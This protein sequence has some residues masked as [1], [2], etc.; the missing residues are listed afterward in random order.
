[1]ACGNCTNARPSAA[2]IRPALH[3]PE[4]HR[5]QRAGPRECEMREQARPFVDVLPAE[6]QEVLL[7]HALNELRGELLPDGSAVLVEYDAPRLV[8]HLPSALPGHVSQVGVFQVERLQHTVEAAQLEELVPV[9][10]ARSAAAVET[11]IQ[12]LYRRVVAVPDAQA[13]VLPPPLRQ[14]GLLAQF[15]RVAEKDLAGHRENI[16]V[17]KAFDQGREKPLVHPHIAVQQDDDIVPRLAKP[18]IRSTAEAQ[19]LRKRQHPHGRECGSHKLRAAV[20]RA[21]VHDD[22]FVVR[23]SGHGGDHR[24]QILFEKVFA[25]PVGNHDRSGRTRSL[26]AAALRVVREQLAAQVRQR[27]RDDRDRQQ[28]RRNQQQRKRLE[29]AFQQRH[30]KQADRGPPRSCGPVLSSASRVPA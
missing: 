8:Q 15:R 9:E 1:M 25:V 4:K 19:V 14:P 3:V 23:M 27:Q 13:A 7:Q 12:I 17:A 26:T 28:Q 16:R 20:R 30:V 29:N 6:Q 11:G 5:Q 10:G 18:G 21:V 2:K 24:R 22:D